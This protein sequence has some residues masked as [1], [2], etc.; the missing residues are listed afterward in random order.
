[1]PWGSPSRGL[2]S[3]WGFHRTAERSKRSVESSSICLRPSLTCYSHHMNYDL[4]PFSWKRLPRGSVQ[5]TRTIALSTAGNTTEFAESMGGATIW[6]M[7]RR[8]TGGQ[9]PLEWDGWLLLLTKDSFTRRARLKKKLFCVGRVREKTVGPY[10]FSLGG[11]IAEDQML[12][13]IPDD[14]LRTEPIQGHLW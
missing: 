4:T 12:S 9:L 11:E 13:N 6:G 5:E 1:M 14:V 3:D 7:S 10:F 2:W 8:D